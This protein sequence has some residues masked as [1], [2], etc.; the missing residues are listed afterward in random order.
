MVPWAFK[1]YNCNFFSQ[2]IIKKYN[3]SLS[4]KPH[5]FD[6]IGALSEQV[7]QKNKQTNKKNN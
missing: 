1:I 4:C 3:Y 2:K 6:C 5:Q 7:R